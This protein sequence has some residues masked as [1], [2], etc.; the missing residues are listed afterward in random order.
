MKTQKWNYK[1]K[2]PSKGWLVHKGDF[3]TMDLNDIFWIHPL[4]SNSGIFPL[5]VLVQNVIC[6]AVC[7]HMCTYHKMLKE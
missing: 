7:Q 5:S 1:T 4:P 3:S 6:V 2:G